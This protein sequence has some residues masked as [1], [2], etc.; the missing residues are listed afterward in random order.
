MSVSLIN[1]TITPGAGYVPHK[2]YDHTLHNG[3]RWQDQKICDQRT[4]STCADQNRFLFASWYSRTQL[5]DEGA[6]PGSSPE[7]LCPTALLKRNKDALTSINVPEKKQNRLMTCDV[8][9]PQKRHKEASVGSSSF[10]AQLLNSSGWITAKAGCAQRKQSVITWS[11]VRRAWKS[12]RSVIARGHIELGNLACFRTCSWIVH[13]SLLQCVSLLNLTIKHC[14]PARDGKI[15]KIVTKEQLLLS[16][17][18]NVIS[19]RL[20]T[21]QLLNEGAIPGLHPR[22]FV[23]DGTLDATT[24]TRTVKK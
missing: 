13:C 8:M 19:L 18:Q 5:L 2:S 3:E 17:E 16:F 7:S 22:V 12:F 10:F 15:K 20:G 24:H 9:E 1:L 6:I 4:I 14:I 23:S 21:I 11:I